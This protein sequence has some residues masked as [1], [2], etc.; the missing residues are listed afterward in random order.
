MRYFQLIFAIIFLMSSCQ[1]GNKSTKNSSEFVLS[2]S[3]AKKLFDY[4]YPLVIMKISKDVMLFNPM[5]EHST[6]NHFIMFDN[7]AEPKNKAVVLGNRNTLYCVGWLDLSKG[8]VLFEIPDMGKRYYVM[9]LID[10]WT[11]T[12]KSIGSR[13]TGQGSQ[14]YVLVNKHYK[15]ELPKGYE[16]VDCPTN[17]VWI[18]G[19]IEA[20][21]EQDIKVA[22]GLQKLYKLVT[23]EEEKTGVDPFKDFKPDFHA[24]EVKKPVPYSL[25]MKPEIFMNTFFEVFNSNESLPGDKVFLDSLKKGGV[26]LEILKSFKEISEANRK[27]ISSAVEAQQKDYLESF[28]EGKSQTKPWTFNIEEMGTW[29]K[30]YHRR[31]YWAI[32]GLGANLVEDAVYGVSQLD[33]SL[34]QLDSDNI[35]RIHFGKN[36]TPE[37]GGFWSITAYDIDG[38]LEKNNIDRYSTGS[39]MSLTYNQDGTLDIYLSATKPNGVANYNWI[40]VPKNKFKLLFRMYWPKESVLNGSYRLPVVTKEK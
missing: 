34:N 16:R 10:A 4:S 11:N 18:T 38:Y 26:D 7:L 27:L 25:K 36:G 35:Y 2:E 3:Q 20:D 12:F 29:G 28:Y 24:M 14:K 9:P 30:N 33:D 17:L 39:N 8:P 40:P 19:R 37:V 22:D 5:R 6:P 13:T 1:E 32:W 15:G 31:A 23:W 21:N